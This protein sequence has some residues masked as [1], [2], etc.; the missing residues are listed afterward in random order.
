LPIPRNLSV[1][2]NCPFDS[3]FQPVFDAMVF[4]AVCCGFVPRCAFESGTSGISR[5]E[6]ITRALVSSK[7]SIHDLS[8]CR[9]EGDI[10][11]A[12]FNMPLELGMA[13]ARATW[14]QDGQ[15]GHDWLLLVPP[16]HVYKKFI[17]DLA[18]FDPAEYDGSAAS[19]VPAVMSWLATRPDAVLSPTPKEVLAI[20]PLFEEQRARLNDDWSGSVPWTDLVVAAIRIAQGED[21]LR[22]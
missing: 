16:G 14:S 22:D 4:V 1:F 7:Y 21:L 19:A 13:L 3:D 5:I 15:P 10:N 12:R 2:I 17:S 9:G 8:R 18:G 6:R 20:L 11:L